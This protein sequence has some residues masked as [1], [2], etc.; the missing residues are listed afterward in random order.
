[1]ELPAPGSD[2]AQP[3]LLRP[4]SSGWKISLSPFSLSLCLSNKSI[5]KKKAWLLHTDSLELELHHHLQAE[6]FLVKLLKL[7]KPQVSHL[8]MWLASQQR[9]KLFQLSA[10]VAVK[11]TLPGLLVWE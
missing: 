11:F 1:M 4:L 6:H 10:V 8:Q 9:S 3:W 2:L 5:G 7:F